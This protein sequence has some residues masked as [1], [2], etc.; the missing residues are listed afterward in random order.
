MASMLMKSSLMAVTAAVLE[1]KYAS[2][3]TLEGSVL[4]GVVGVTPMLIVGT[5]FWA[6]I[7]GFMVVG[8]ARK[9]YMDLAKKDGEK[10]VEERYDLPNLY[11]QGTSKH[12]RAFNCVQRSHQH[13]FETFSQT[14]ASALIG[15]HIYPISS[16]ILMA[17]YTVGRIT[18]SQGYAATE[19]DASKRYSSKFAFFTWYGV[20]SL[21]ALAMVAAAKMM[22]G[23]KMF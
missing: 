1:S 3:T 21:H 13:I 16:A 11:A 4:G 5:G 22:L 17:M 14:I 23:G 10:E 7:H 18:L 19:G 20:M 2:S 12:A 15:W 9:K 6:V 8:K